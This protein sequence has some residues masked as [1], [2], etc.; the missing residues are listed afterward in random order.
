FQLDA[1]VPQDV[2]LSPADFT[3]PDLARGRL[4]SARDI[5]W[6]DA[7]PDNPEAVGRLA[8]GMTSV[9]TN[10]MPRYDTF[11]VQWFGME[12]YA[13]ELFSPRSDRII[14]FSGPVFADDDATV[15]EIRVPQRFWKVLV[16]T[17]PA[18]PAS[19]FVEAYLIAQVERDGRKLETGQGFEPTASRV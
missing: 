8:Y 15:G 4:V 11:N 18:N 16:A 7:L 17:Q 9:M 1:R 19:V 2:Q 13:R 6:G 3:N 5:A 10:V 12:R 14:I